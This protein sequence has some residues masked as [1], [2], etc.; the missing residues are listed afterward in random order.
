[1]QVEELCHFGRDGCEAQGHD[2]LDAL[3]DDR[4]GDRFEPVQ[5]LAHFSAYGFVKVQRSS[6]SEN[7]RK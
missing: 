7:L 4:I 2:N 5:Q 1:V 3:A 6:H